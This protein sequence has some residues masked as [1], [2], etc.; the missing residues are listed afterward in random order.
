M[1]IIGIDLGTSFC[2]V[3]K[4]NDLG[5]AEIVPFS[6]DNSSHLL[7]S[8]VLIDGSNIYVGKKCF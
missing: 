1:N 4:I 2:A 7:P 6:N 8:Q 5:K 3:A